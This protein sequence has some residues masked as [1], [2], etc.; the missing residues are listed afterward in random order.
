M[1]HKVEELTR[2][3]DAI[4][5]RIEGAIRA[6]LDAHESRDTERARAMAEQIG[7]SLM[8]RLLGEDLVAGADAARNKRALQQIL[9][10]GV[11][12]WPIFVRM[13]TRLFWFFSTAVVGLLLVSFIG[14]GT[15]IEIVR[16]KLRLWF[17]S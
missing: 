6:A 10:Q 13:Q 17:G 3:L 4:P 8:E 16:L 14:A 15:I 1:E 11:M 7:S 9:R 5:A 12:V 2:Q